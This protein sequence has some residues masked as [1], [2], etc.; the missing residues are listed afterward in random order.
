[1]S[2]GQNT[3]D[4]ERRKKKVEQNMAGGVKRENKTSR[5]R[6]KTSVEVVNSGEKKLL[7]ECEGQKQ[8]RFV[9]EKRRQMCFQGREVKMRRGS[10]EIL[11]APYTPPPPPSHSPISLH[12][13]CFCM[14]DSVIP[15]GQKRSLSFSAPVLPFLSCIYFVITMSQARLDVGCFVANE[16]E[17]MKQIPTISENI[18]KKK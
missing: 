4:K 14:S 18:Y 15:G 12:V 2:K 1:M 8:K 9:A 5:L 16:T 13:G 10:Q 6:S 7:L 3:Q 11:H 17:W